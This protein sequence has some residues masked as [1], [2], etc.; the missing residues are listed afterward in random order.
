M[1]VQHLCG[2]CESFY[3]VNSVIDVFAVSY[4]HALGAVLKCM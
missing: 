1:G 2:S 4:G 3:Q